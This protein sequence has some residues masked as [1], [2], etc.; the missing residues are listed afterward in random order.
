MP[1]IGAI[2][3]VLVW[4][5]I[6]SS[7]WNV[8]GNWDLGF[9]PPGA[10]VAL[11][12][13]AAATR[14]TISNDI[15]LS[16]APALEL[17]LT[18]S[19][20]VISGNG[21]PSCGIAASYTSGTSSIANAILAHGSCAEIE[22]QTAAG[23]TLVLSGDLPA[24]DIV[25]S[26]AGA[27]RFT[28]SDTSARDLTIEGSV[29][30]VESNWSGTAVTLDGGTLAGAGQLASI[31]GGNGTVSPGGNSPMMGL[32]PIYSAAG[33]GP[34]TITSGN[35]TLGAGTTLELELNGTVASLYDRLAVTGTVSLGGATLTPT[36]G[37][38]PAA[39]S[40]TTLTIVDNDGADAVVG[41]FA[42][43]AEGATFAVGG[44]TVR[45]SYVGGTGND[46]T[47]TFLPA[48]V[49]IVVAPASL[50]LMTVGAAAA[51]AI[52]ASGGTAPYT[53]A[54]T[55]GALPAGL[56]LSAAGALSGTPTA[57]GA[58][59]FTVTA[60][61]AGANTGT[62]AYTGAI[63]SAAAGLTI[64]PATLPGMTVGVP[65]SQAITATGGTAPYTFAVTA[66][67]LPAG[68]TLTA[69]GLLSGTPTTAETYNFSVT[70]T[71]SGI[72]ASLGGTTVASSASQAYSG[73]VAAPVPSMPAI[74]LGALAGLLFFV[75]RR[76]MGV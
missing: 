18:G 38:V 22:I 74:M 16:A 20:Y 73:I 9:V 42:G 67:A 44:R 31:T 34:G 53:F 4:T 33:D 29:A 1:S 55:A 69:A 32:G 58:Y 50:P 21:I 23:G 39:G 61:D 54:V 37:F 62:R 14:K 68:L 56:A 27:I 43:L 25:T 52:T 26:G 3:L 15:D 47:L 6:V 11:E 49:A 63:G 28:A 19:G 7:L 30:I 12:F 8:A 48:A 17:R 76:Q 40:S 64:S 75:A 65:F 13:P 72:D 10:A 5:G 46:V 36:L 51:Q 45:V 24:T 41:T 71:D 66:G 60:T 70:A 57:A 35:V 2:G 59:S